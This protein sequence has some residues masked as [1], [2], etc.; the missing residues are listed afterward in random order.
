MLVQ[1][2]YAHPCFHST[3]IF[4]LISRRTAPIGRAAKLLTYLDAAAFMHVEFLYEAFCI[5]VNNGE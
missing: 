2:L 1:C 4:C 5:I 3:H